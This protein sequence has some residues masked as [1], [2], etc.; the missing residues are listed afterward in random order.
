MLKG[1]F[2]ARNTRTTEICLPLNFLK[3]ETTVNVSHQKMQCMSSDFSRILVG[4]FVTND[5]SLAVNQLRIRSQS[6]FNSQLALFENN[7]GISHS[8]KVMIFA[9]VSH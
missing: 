5:L 4:I 2:Q 3:K 6:W 7:Y 1:F 8:S 9:G